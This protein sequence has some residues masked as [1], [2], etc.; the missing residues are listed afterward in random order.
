M[1]SSD[2]NL[3]Q[4]L[5]TAV[6]QV[7]LK[8]LGDVSPGT[9]ISELGLDSVAVMELIGVLEETLS[10]RIGDEEV[11]SLETVSDL[12][13]LIRGRIPAQLPA[14]EDRLQDSSPPE[15]DRER[16]DIRS[17][18]EVRICEAGGHRR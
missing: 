1:H 6:R 7:S 8:E 11:A 18:P 3:I 5:K 4:V 14:R 16:W 9:K 10:I 12:L 15:E 17:F 2:E 13:R